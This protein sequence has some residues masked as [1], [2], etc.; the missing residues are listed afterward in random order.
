MKSSSIKDWL[1]DSVIIIG[2]AVAAVY[3]LPLLSACIDALSLHFGR[4]LF[5]VRF[6]ALDNLLP[7]VVIGSLLG[8]AAAWLIRHRKLYIACLPAVAVSA[9]YALYS[10]FGPVQIPWSWSWFDFVIIGGW[11]LLIAASLL[12][13][14]F[15]LRKRQPNTALEPTPT[16]P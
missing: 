13:A 5:W 11:L 2:L 1:I 9:F 7:P 4:T 8:L 3:L 10:V 6:I 14:W 15:I 16:A 12:C